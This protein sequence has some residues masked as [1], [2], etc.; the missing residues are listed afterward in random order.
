MSKLL[1]AMIAGLFASRRVSPRPK[2][3]E[4]DPTAKGK[5]AERAEA[6]KDAK[7]AG[8][9]KAPGGDQSKVAEGSAGVHRHKADDGRREAR[10]DRATRAAATRTAARSASATQGGTPQ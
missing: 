3:A 8:L 6:K 1:A 9:V 10:R 7:P 2:P 5:A 4:I